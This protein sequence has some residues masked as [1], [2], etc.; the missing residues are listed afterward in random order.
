M[1]KR[2]NY[3]RKKND[4]MPLCAMENCEYEVGK[5]IYEVCDYCASIGL[6]YDFNPDEFDKK[7]L[8]FTVPKD[9]INLLREIRTVASPT[10]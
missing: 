4:K 5:N 7:I 8:G 10:N 6:P 2:C 3:E 9:R 1:K